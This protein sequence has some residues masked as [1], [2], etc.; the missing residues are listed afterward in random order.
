M[1][2]TASTKTRNVD[3]YV[4]VHKALRALMTDTLT[5]VG[6]LDPE[7]AFEISEG[8]AQVRLLLT[9]CRDHLHHENQAIHPAM[10]ARSP[11]SSST[12]TNDHVHHEEAFENLETAVLDVEH[13]IE[14][15]RA[16]TL[17]ALYR[18]LSIF[19]AENFEH[20]IVEE[21]ENMEVLWGNYTD[22]E[23][24]DIHKA[25]L[26]AVKPATM[27]VYLEWMIPSLSAPER[28]GV[29]RG[30]RATAP[31]DVFRGLLRLA[32]SRLSERDWEKLATALNLVVQEEAPVLA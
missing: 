12:T 6:R 5:T 18:S 4:G 24:A 21:T 32:Q 23:L 19:V 30:I 27:A 11:G 16:G 8:L 14:T 10:E 1:K 17:L 26:S 9:L 7:D 2:P 28:A 15:V 20:M 22:D 31:P 25:I 13:S 29:L 3:L